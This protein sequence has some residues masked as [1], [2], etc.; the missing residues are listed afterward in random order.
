MPLMPFGYPFLSLSSW[1][2]FHVAACTHSHLWILA[3][4][5]DAQCLCHKGYPCDE[6]PGSLFSLLFPCTQAWVRTSSIHSFEDLVCVYEVCGQ[7]LMFLWSESTW[8]YIFITVC[9]SNR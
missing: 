8:N 3:P 7:N 2:L 4:E 1:R 6:Y 5:R 9:L